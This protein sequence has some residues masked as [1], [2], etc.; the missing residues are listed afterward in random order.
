MA[1][2]R[3]ID[4]LLVGHGMD[5]MAPTILKKLGW[6]V[7]GNQMEHLLGCHLGR[8]GLTVT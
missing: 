5:V 6:D 3:F 1:A 7:I 2:L 4:C 8:G